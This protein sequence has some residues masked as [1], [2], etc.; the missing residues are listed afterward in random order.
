MALV[1]Y[2]GGCEHAR[3]FFGLCKPFEGGSADAL[4]SAGL[5]AWFP[6]SGTEYAYSGTAERTGCV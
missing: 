1:G 5:G 2:F 6:H 4:E 3:G